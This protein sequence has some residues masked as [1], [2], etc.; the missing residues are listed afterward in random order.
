MRFN[1]EVS[2]ARFDKDTGLWTI[3]TAMGQKY[4]ARH[5]VLASGPLHEPQI[6]N[7]KGLDSFKGKVMHSA[8][9]DKSYD[10]EGK[11]V[12]SIGTCR[13]ALQYFPEIAP[14]VEQF[15]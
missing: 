8:Q 3:D 11:K 1:R 13:S 2:G 15:V 9:W 6:P 12:V 14:D 4:R 10:M 5:F 7:I